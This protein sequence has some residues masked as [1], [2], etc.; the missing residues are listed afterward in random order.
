MQGRFDSVHNCD[1][2]WSRWRF[3]HEHLNSKAGLELASFPSVFAN[4]TGP[5]KGRLVLL[6]VTTTF[7][8][9]FLLKSSLLKCGDAL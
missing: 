7:L 3:H 8:L 4:E 1:E 2:G 5:E 9:H 6:F